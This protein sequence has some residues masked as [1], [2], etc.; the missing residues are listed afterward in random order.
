M[1]DFAFTNT[2]IAYD[3]YIY[4]YQKAENEKEALQCA[5]EKNEQFKDC[6]IIKK[7]KGILLKYGARYCFE[8]DGK[9]WYVYDVEK[10]W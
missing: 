8:Y 7:P 10:G 2:D 9:Y 5:I 3:G 1:K 4:Y 6:K